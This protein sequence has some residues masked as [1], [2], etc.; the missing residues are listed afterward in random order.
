M[1]KIKFVFFI[2]ILVF[3]YSICLSD[4][5]SPELQKIIENGALKAKELGLNP[6]P[7]IN[8]GGM[9]AIPAGFTFRIENGNVVIRDKVDLLINATGQTLN[10]QG[11]PLPHGKFGYFKDGKMNIVN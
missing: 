6:L 5:L 2:L 11:T 9:I 8:N 7:Y 1:N 4:T 3:S 10:T